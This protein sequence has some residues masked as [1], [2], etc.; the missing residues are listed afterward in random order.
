[1]ILVVWAIQNA[2]LETA[3]V[4]RGRSVPV[5]VTSGSFQLSLSDAFT[6]TKSKRI[7]A[8]QAYKSPGGLCLGYSHYLMLLMLFTDSDT[9]TMRGLDIIQINLQAKYDYQFRLRDCVYGFEATMTVLC[10]SLYTDI[11]PGTLLPEQ[12]SAY[13]ITEKCA[14]SY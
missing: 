12:G 8:A 11:A 2:Y 3:E 9:L 14:V 13:E 6:M 1:M 5:L 10:P 7:A 4:I